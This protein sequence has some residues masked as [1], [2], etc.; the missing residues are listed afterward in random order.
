MQRK[1]PC[2]PIVDQAAYD[3]IVCKHCNRAFTTKQAMYRHIRNS[4]KAALDKQSTPDLVE[5]PHQKTTMWVNAL[6]QD[7]TWKRRTLGIATLLMQN[8]AITAIKLIPPAKEMDTYI[9]TLI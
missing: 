3:G 6:F 8:G 9:D 5:K 1:T 4:C 2:D 7:G